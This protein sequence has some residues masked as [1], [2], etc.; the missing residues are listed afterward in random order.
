MMHIYSQ[1]LRQAMLEGLFEEETRL[2]ARLMEQHRR[3][4]QELKE[5]SDRITACHITRSGLLHAMN[6]KD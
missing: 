5:L 1:E 4:R 3:Q 2:L 6:R